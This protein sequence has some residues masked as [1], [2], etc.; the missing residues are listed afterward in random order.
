ME[1]FIAY[2][3]LVAVAFWFIRNTYKKFKG[4]NGSCG[5]SGGCGGCSTKTDLCDAG[6]KL[7]NKELH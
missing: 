6:E 5:C 3:I 2:C 4:D 1:D 7:Y